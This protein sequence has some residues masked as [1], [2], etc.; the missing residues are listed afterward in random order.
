VHVTEDCLG[1][2]GLTP[3]ACATSPGE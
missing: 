3:V 2:D 1:G